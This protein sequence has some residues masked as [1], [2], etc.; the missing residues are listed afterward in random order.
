MMTNEDLTQ[1]SGVHLLY[2]LK[3]FWWLTEVTPY[4][5]GS[6]HSAL[7][8]SWV[9]HLRNLICFFCRPERNKD[10]V[11]AQDFFDSPCEWLEA[12]SPT[13]K[14]ARERA[15][16][17]LSHITES[18]KYVGGKDKAWQV[19]RLFGEIEQIA[20][21]FVAEASKKKLHS[22]VAQFLSVD[23]PR[24]K[25]VLGEQSQSTDTASYGPSLDSMFADTKR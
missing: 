3:M 10:N 25:L 24:V 22:D 6:M 19:A 20:K 15:N 11:L 8:E 14:A 5:E 21:K 9:V 13:L 12:E 1:F 2:E 4:M 18:R 17:E 23:S 7:L 16:K